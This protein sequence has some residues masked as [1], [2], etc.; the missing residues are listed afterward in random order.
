MKSLPWCVQ[1]FWIILF[2]PLYL[3]YL[4]I[5]TLIIVIATFSLFPSLHIHLSSSSLSPSTPKHTHVSHHS[6]RPPYI[7]T[8]THLHI[9][10]RSPMMTE[11]IRCQ[12]SEFH[13]RK[14]I[15]HSLRT[16][17]NTNEH[18]YIYPHINIYINTFTFLHA[19]IY[20]HKHTH[21]D[22]YLQISFEKTDPFLI[23]FSLPFLPSIATSSF[24]FLRFF[25]PD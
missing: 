22:A 21:M 1:F 9:T 24:L 5:F 3:Q 23:I 10:F 6:Y 11:T 17:T 20:T 18:T 19:H 13:W 16:L 4:V 12:S 7:S 25:L 15:I 2:H 14:L 8:V